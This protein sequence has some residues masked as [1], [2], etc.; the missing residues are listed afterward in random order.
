MIVLIMHYPL[1]IWIRNF[2]FWSFTF[3]CKD[4]MY[5]NMNLSILMWHIE[6]WSNVPN[7][8]LSYFWL[9]VWKLR[10]IICSI[11]I[12]MIVCLWKIKQ[13]HTNL[14]KIVSYSKTN[15]FQ[16]RQITQFSFMN[17]FQPHISTF[18]YQ[19]INHQVYL[20]QTSVSLKKKIWMKWNCSTQP[21]MT[22]M[23]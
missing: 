13:H 10:T 8:S 14:W 21:L 22:L 1:N 3:R 4:A 20:S 23:A 11:L 5:C 9:E 19:L 2:L 18:I 12:E 15:H 7:R 6:A 16:C 17:Y